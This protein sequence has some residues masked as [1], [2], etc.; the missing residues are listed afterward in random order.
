[1]KLNYNF[2]GVIVISTALQIQGCTPDIPLVVED[3]NPNILIS[4]VNIHPGYDV[5]WS[6][7]WR[8]GN[9]KQ[10]MSAADCLIGDTCLR[11]LPFIEVERAENTNVLNVTQFVRKRFLLTGVTCRERNPRTGVFN[12]YTCNITMKSKLFADTF[13]ILFNSVYRLLVIKAM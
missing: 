3:N 2:Y 13:V 6:L 7:S 10:H 12:G 9:L 4:C 5:Y 8:R 11:W 1:M